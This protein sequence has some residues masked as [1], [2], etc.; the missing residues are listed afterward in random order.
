MYTSFCILF[1]NLAFLHFLF[2][3][4]FLLIL[5]EQHLIYAYLTKY[6]VASM[7][8]AAGEEWS[9]LVYSLAS[10]LFSMEELTTSSV[11]GRAC[12]EAMR[13]SLDGGKV[14]AIT[15]ALSDHHF[16]FST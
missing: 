6:S 8:R 16:F 9:R 11:T 10:A 3:G 14:E 5:F 15:G 12:G 4:L 1:D 2:R 13:P 7:S